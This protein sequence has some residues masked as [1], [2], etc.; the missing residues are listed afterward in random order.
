[1][2]KQI[3]TLPKTSR[4]REKKYDFSE[5]FD[6]KT[7]LIVQGEDFDCQVQSIRAHIYREV[8]ELGK[9]VRSREVEQDGK[10]ALAF[11]VVNEPPKKRQNGT[12]DT[13]DKE[14]KASTSKS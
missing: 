8:T 7:W 12:K 1:M 5:L 6:G 13:A 3:E 10:P 14:A 9:S 2:P 4:G 11:K